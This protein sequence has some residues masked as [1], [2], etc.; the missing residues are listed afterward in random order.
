MPLIQSCDAIDEDCRLLSI[1]EEGGSVKSFHQGSARYSQLLVDIILQ[2]ADSQLAGATGYATIVNSAPTLND[3]TGLARIVIEKLEMAQRSYALLQNH[4]GMDVEQYV[5]SHGWEARV[6]RGARL[7]LRRPVTDRRW[8]ALMFPLEGWLDMT[9][10]AY[11]MSSM[12]CLMLEN[13]LSCSFS[14]LCQLATE[15]LPV[16]QCHQSFG[17]QQLRNALRDARNGTAIQASLDYWFNRV[18][19]CFDSDNSARNL[20]CKKFA[21]KECTN[22]ELRRQWSE[23]VIGSCE[24]LSLKRPD[25]DF[26]VPGRRPPLCS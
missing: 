15:C 5:R 9:V 8:H 17:Q 23:A 25:R 19:A 4:H 10:F 26:D 2:F 18:A 24:G 13:F 12:T 1:I 21:L 7:A 6:M 14:P 11:L 20:L 3:R 22:C 16:E